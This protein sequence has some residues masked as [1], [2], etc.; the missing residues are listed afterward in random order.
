LQSERIVAQKKAKEQKVSVLL[1]FS[2][3]KKKQNLF[4]VLPP[5]LPLWRG[6]NSG[7]KKKQHK[8]L[9]SKNSHP[10]SFPQQQLLFLC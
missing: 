7:A 6:A 9:V 8:T 2:C 5:Q 4:S 3:C 1:V 10:F